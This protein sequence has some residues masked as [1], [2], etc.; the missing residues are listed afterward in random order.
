MDWWKEG[1]TRWID[2]VYDKI[3][4]ENINDIAGHT[5]GDNGT[6]GEVFGN[7]YQKH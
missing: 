4:R 5:V 2:T 6:F 7:M 1:R 3:G